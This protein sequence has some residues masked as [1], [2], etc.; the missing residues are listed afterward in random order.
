MQHF[1]EGFII[2]YIQYLIPAQRSLVQEIGGKKIFI[3]TKELAALSKVA[4][5]RSTL[6]IEGKKVMLMTNPFF[7]L[8]FLAH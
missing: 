4:E 3:L 7:Q 1:S 2:Q 6:N 8:Q 5:D